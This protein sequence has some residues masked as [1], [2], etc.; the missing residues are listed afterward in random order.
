MI[1]SARMHLNNMPY[2][3]VIVDGGSSD[4]TLEWLTKQPDVVLVA[5]GKKEGAVRAFNAGFCAANGKIVFNLND[6]C[7]IVGDVFGQAI[8]QLERNESIGQVAIPFRCP[9]QEHPRLYSISVGNPRREMRY[10]QFGA[11]RRW[12]G[13][14]LGWWGGLTYQYSGDPR[15]SMCI[16]NSG[17]KVADLDGDAYIDH[18]EAKDST[19]LPNTDSHLLF[20]AW[21]AWQGPPST[22]TVF[23]P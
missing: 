12:L 8:A 7:V 1:H 13:N 10:A 11:T 18:I 3:F 6:D 5:Q 14:A 21:R 19:R 15:L 22:P 20:E 4:G 16:W 2:E 23:E 9:S 17:Y